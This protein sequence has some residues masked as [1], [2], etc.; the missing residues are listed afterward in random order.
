[1]SS[2]QFQSNTSVFILV[3]SL[4]IF[5]PLYSISGKLAV[6]IL[7]VFTYL[8]KPSVYKQS[9]PLL[10]PFPLPRCPSD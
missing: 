2:L 3:L 10:P 6:F 9:L 7:N 1:M 4:S 5:V 8:I